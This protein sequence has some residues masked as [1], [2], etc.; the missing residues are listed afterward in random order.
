[1][2]TI[3]SLL[4]LTFFFST[5][6]IAQ[7]LDLSWI[8]EDAQSKARY[9]DLRHKATNTTVGN[10][11]D[12]TFHRLLFTV[13]PAERYITGSVTSYFRHLSEPPH[14]LTFN[15]H[16]SLHLNAIRYH[17]ELIEGVHENNV[18]SI[19]LPEAFAYG[20]TDSI[21]VDY[22]GVPVTDTIGF[23]S[24]F[25]DVHGPDSI[26]VMYTLSEPYG[27]PYW[28]PCKHNLNDKI[29][30]V[31]LVVTTP[32]EYLT[33][34]NGVLTECLE[35]EDKR[36]MQ[37][38]HR[39]PIPAYL[40]AI[41]VTNYERYS[42]YVQLDNGDSLEIL[43]YVY[44]EDLED[45]KSKTPGLFEVFDIFNE[46]FG[47]YPYADEK[48]GH[49]QWNQG[50]GMEHQTMSYMGSFGHDLMAHELAHQWFGDYVTCGSW[51]DI[52]L[53]EGFATY[54]T[55]LTYERMFNGIYW[56]QFKDLSTKRVV[57]EPGGSVFCP[58][59]TVND[60]IFSARL[61]YSKGAMVLHQLRWELGDEAFFGG[62]N[63]YY[64][65]HAN[66]YALTTDLQNHLDRY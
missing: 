28:W 12:L 38:F 56:W 19:T 1:M 4:A 57:K 61:S 15:M 50:G 42:E 47:L 10:T 46:L 49:A 24:F 33:A 6:I 60:R 35:C 8:D 66:G 62:I 64:N 20:E 11:Y 43:N 3:L 37:W 36:V 30:S 39:H 34:S 7:T 54:L 14:V 5:S 25:T 23:G 29:D 41:A 58:D 51:Q 63:S 18:L 52:W 13:D 48:Y 9:L 31:H 45:I 22:E 55:G 26:P 21:M 32:P 59:T 16:D 17:G 53:N 27:S 65:A 2:K 44:P 40:V